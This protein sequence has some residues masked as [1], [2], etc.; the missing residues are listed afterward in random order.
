MLPISV[1]HHYAHIHSKCIYIIPSK[2]SRNTSPFLANQAQSRYIFYLR[3]SKREKRLVITYSKV[4][5]NI[6]KNK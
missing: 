6:K 4:L 2:A 3:I 5:S 1:S